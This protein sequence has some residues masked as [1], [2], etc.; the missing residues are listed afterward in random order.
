MARTL[1]NEEDYD[2]KFT[3]A[4]NFDSVIPITFKSKI[5]DFYIELEPLN[6]PIL[7]KDC[8]FK[9]RILFC[10]GSD[11]VIATTENQV[12]QEDIFTEIETNEFKE[13]VEFKEC[14]FNLHIQFD[15]IKFSD[16]FIMQE[17]N[18]KIVSFRN[19]T[20]N[21]LADFW[22]TTFKEKVI[23]YK[24]DFNATAVF[25][26][27]KFEENVLFTYSL[28]A[29][30]IIFRGTQF[31]KNVDFSLAIISGELNLFDLNLKESKAPTEPIDISETEYENNVSKVGLVPIKNYRETLRIIKHYFIKNEDYFTAN[32]FSRLEKKEITKILKQTIFSKKITKRIIE[33]INIEFTEIKKTNTEP[34]HYIKERR[35]IETNKVLL[36]QK[37]LSS[38]YFF[39]MIG[40]FFNW[41]SNNHKNSYIQAI[42]FTFVIG[43]ISF[44]VSLTLVSEKIIIDNCDFIIENLK[45]HFFTF[46]NPTHKKISL[47]CVVEDHNEYGIKYNAINFL[48]RLFVGYGFY[49][50]IQAFRKLK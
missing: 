2:A 22:R 27:V 44:Y 21:S 35:S 46:L 50:T 40:L 24:T 29:D 18:V 17:C 31:K 30:K 23:F 16:K 8:E 3:L 47:S 28:I 36:K 34:Y 10:K 15:D 43:L 9:K 1:I 20:F 26:A 7:F 32:I 6:R 12:N 38:S 4:A 41:I 13:K 11:E 39:D 19:T 14:D 42:I 25:S 48:G 37:Y 45:N 33:K 49:Q 5:F